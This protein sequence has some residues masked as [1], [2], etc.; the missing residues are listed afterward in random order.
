M[1]NTIILFREKIFW[2]KMVEGPFLGRN[3]HIG[4][5]QYYKWAT[6]AIFKDSI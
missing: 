2:Y 3:V 4:A 6:G 5:I 1:E